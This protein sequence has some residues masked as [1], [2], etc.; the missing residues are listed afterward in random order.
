M[1]EIQEQNKYDTWYCCT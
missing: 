1:K